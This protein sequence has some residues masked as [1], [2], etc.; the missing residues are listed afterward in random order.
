MKI[1]ELEELKRIQLDI[2]TEVDKFCSDNQIRY[3]IS[4]GTLLGAVRHRGYIPWDDDIDIMMPRPDYDRFIHT[5]QSQGDLWV[6]TYM[7]DESYWQPFAKVIN[8]K[9]VLEESSLRTGVFINIFPIDGMPDEKTTQKLVD[10]RTHLVFKDLYYDSKTYRFKK[11]NRVI[12]YLKYLIKK[13]L[14]KGRD[15][16]IKELEAISRKYPFETS[17]YAGCIMWGYGLKERMPRT[18]FESYSKIEFEG[19]FFSC[20][21]NYDKYLSSLFGDYMKLPLVDERISHHHFIAYWK[22]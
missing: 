17:D 15:Y 4:G 1:I 7:S 14:S 16:A 5:F 18:V 20:V 8:S 21:A 22:S 13:F 11:G 10:R 2:L 3:S 6:Q 9:T 19:R 12:L